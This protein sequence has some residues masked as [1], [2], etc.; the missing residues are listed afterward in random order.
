LHEGDTLTVVSDFLAGVASGLLGAIVGGAFTA[1]G[2]RAQVKAIVETANLQISA[3]REQQTRNTEAAR[4]LSDLD[5]LIETLSVLRYQVQVWGEEHYFGNHSG[6]ACEGSIPDATQ[7]R[8]VNEW[9]RV[10]DKITYRH[11]LLLGEMNASDAHLDSFY[12]FLPFG[13]NWRDIPAEYEIENLCFREFWA[14][15]FQGEITRLLDR[16]VAARSAG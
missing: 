14:D 13:N 6:T 4:R 15:D 3:E 8:Q 10:V 2:A 5:D 1:Q 9:R 16:V 12:H 11:S 7:M